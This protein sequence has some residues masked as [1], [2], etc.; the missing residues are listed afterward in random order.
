VAVGGAG[1]VSVAWY[2]RRNDL[3][4]NLMIDVYKAFSEDGGSTFDPIIRV[5]DVNF[6]VPPI[7]PN[8]D[9]GIRS[10]YMGEYIAIAAD[11]H[12]FYYLW[13]D[14]RNTLVTVNWPG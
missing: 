8:F 3:A 9:V 11:T 12:N 13:G 10:C 14:N 1:A 4:N 6:A 2:D 7:L 5:T